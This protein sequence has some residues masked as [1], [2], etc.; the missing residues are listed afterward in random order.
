MSKISKGDLVEIVSPIRSLQKN[1][2]YLCEGEIGIAISSYPSERKIS[3]NIS[4]LIGGKVWGVPANS[5]RVCVSLVSSK[6]YLSQ[7]VP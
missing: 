6:N 2:T 5:V 4:V 3:Q 1:V 7:V